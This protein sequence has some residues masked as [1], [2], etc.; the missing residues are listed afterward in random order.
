MRN[1]TLYTI[2]YAGKDIDTFIACLKKYKITCLID[3]RTSPFS[4]TFPEYNGSSLKERLKKEGII[5]AHF[6]KEFG[7]RRE[8][9]EAYSFV[10]GMDGQYRETV[11]FEKV[12]QLE[13]FKKGFERVESALNQG[14]TICFMCS[15]KR[16]VHCHR[17]WMVGLF[18][19]TRSF[20]YEIINII[21]LEEAQT[22]EE[23]IAE[24][25]YQKDRNKFYKEHDELNE[26]SLIPL[27]VPAWVSFW[28]SLF[29]SDKSEWMKIQD[30][31]NV[32]IGYSK[33]EEEND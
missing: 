8:E 10:Y 4:K 6:G 30:Y 29:K 32:M 24:S 26:F 21:S 25:S 22:V 9:N 13:A 1:N 16:P 23:T 14:Y 31:S 19:A 17:F 12:Y 27:K 18:Y 33:G 28:D 7:A 20:P 3:V 15:E 11:C 5:Y 2:G